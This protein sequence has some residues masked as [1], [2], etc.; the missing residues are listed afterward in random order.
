MDTIKTDAPAALLKTQE[1][2]QQLLRNLLGSS[3][4]WGGQEFEG[5]AGAFV[6][7]KNR[8]AGLRVLGVQ[9]VGDHRYMS[10]DFP[11]KHGA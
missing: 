11:L 5:D 1:K 8:A 2:R 4:V 6:H 3:L 9:R 10:A 7:R